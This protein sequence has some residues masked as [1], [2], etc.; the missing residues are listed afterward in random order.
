MSSWNKVLAYI[1]EVNK[2]VGTQRLAQDAAKLK[3]K[4]RQQIKDKF[5]V[6]YHCQN[7]N[8]EQRC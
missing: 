2:P 8:C 1:L 7:V 3:D 6:Q 4:E 5:K